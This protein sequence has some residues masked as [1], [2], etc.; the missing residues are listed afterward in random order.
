MNKRKIGAIAALAAASLVLAGCSGGGQTD[1]AAPSDNG[2]LVIS[3]EV[4]ASAKV[5]EAAKK[6]GTIV[7]YTGGSEQSEREVADAFTEATGIEVEIVRLAP[8]KLSERVL[9]EV[10]ANK[11]GADVIRISGE[12]LVAALAD[13]DVFQPTKLTDDISS[14]LI[15]EATHED[16]LYYNS[17]DRLYSFGY[18]NQ[19]VDKKDAPENWSDLLDSKFA[20]KSGIVQVGAGGSTAALTRFQLDVLGQNWLKDYAANKPRIF[21]S[22]ASL[23]D[24]LARGEISVGSIPIATAYTA[25]LEGAP[26]TIATPKEGA[27]AYP[28]YLGQAAQS[29]R[30]NAATVFVNWLM[31]E[32]G[33][34]LAA[35]IGDY[36]VHEGMP[37]P[38]IGDI[39][40]PSADSDF[41]YRAT[42]DESLANLE[43]DSK[44][45]MEIFGYT[46]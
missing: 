11:L 28:F 7:F 1:A 40:L 46:G 25:M 12:D 39:E 21:D 38:T 26:I 31:S 17:F 36:P 15:P 30:S 29:K 27:A 41:A 43:P 5:Y 35:S 9:S 2:D 16:G 33:Q 14:A 20:G 24:A 23:T 34:K 18:N 10:A 42:L 44:L 4:I 22:S 45:W 32:S 3:A 6:E 19:V 13:A 8:N 37:N